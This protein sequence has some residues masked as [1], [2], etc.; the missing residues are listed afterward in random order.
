MKETNKIVM[1]GLSMVVIFA[2]V[3]A[4]FSVLSEENASKKYLFRCPVCNERLEY[5]KNESDS[6]KVICPDCGMIIIFAKDNSNE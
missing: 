1:I 4:V 3:Q 6:S 2:L 5:A